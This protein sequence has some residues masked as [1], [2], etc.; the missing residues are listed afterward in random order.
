MTDWDTMARPEKALARDYIF[1][2]LGRHQSGLFLPAGQCLCVRKA[3]DYGVLDR[4][5]HIVAV[6]RDVDV[7][8]IMRRTL[9]TLPV[10]STVHEGQLHTLQLDQPLDLAF[11]DLNGL[12]DANIARWVYHELAPNLSPDAAVIFTLAHSWRNNRFMPNCQRYLLRHRYEFVDALAD[13]LSCHDMD[14][15]CTVALFRVLFHGWS[16]KTA[17]RLRYR[18]QGSVSMDAYRLYD[19]TKTNDTMGRI[20][21]G[22][23]IA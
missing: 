23:A 1:D 8:H 18:D 17:Y 21:H 10:S 14:L 7:A 9:A 20:A 12:L 15:V 3:L 13:E 4:D 6:E 5:S 19:F 2:S 11:I 22:L 16:F